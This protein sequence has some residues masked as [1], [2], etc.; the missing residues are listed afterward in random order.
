MEIYFSAKEI[1]LTQ[2]QLLVTYILGGVIQHHC[3]NQNMN[4]AVQL[5]GYD[6]VSEP[7]PYWLAKNQWGRSFGEDGY[8]RIKYGENMCGKIFHKIDRNFTIREI[9]L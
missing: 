1:F 7:I 9:C 6:L 5:I 4:H 3:T 2:I 8:V